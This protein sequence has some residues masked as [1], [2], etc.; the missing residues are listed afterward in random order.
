MASLSTPLLGGAIHERGVV[1]LIM[2]DEEFNYLSQLAFR[3]SGIVINESKR[4]MLYGRV[5]KRIRSLKLNGFTAYCQLL[6]DS[7][8]GELSAFINAITTNLTAFFREEYHFNFL[9]KVALAHFKHHNQD[10]RLRLWSA[11]CSTG[12]EPYSIAMSV[13]GQLPDWDVKI[14]ATDLDSDVLWCAHQGH[15]DDLTGIPQHYR[16]Q[17]CANECH[18][19]GY[20]IGDDIK[21]VIAFKQLNLLSRWPMKGQFDVIFCRNVLIYFD[22][23][24][25][26]KLIQ[27]FYAQLKPGGYLFLGH[28][29]SLQSLN[30]KFRLVGQTIYQR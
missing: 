13:Q 24:T 7:Y 5:M 14:L 23:E 19:H 26:Q 1:K 8:T 21:Q 4:D 29:E 16:T 10:K 18:Q 9:Q 12:Q 27:R 20:L 28:S 6:Q 2:Q 30:T 3:E 11:G 22:N 15:Y 17:Y 25:K